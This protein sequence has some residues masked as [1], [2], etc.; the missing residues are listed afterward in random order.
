LAR[1]KLWPGTSLRR[2]QTAKDG[3]DEGGLVP[4]ASVLADSD[5]DEVV[6]GDDVHPLLRVAVEVED[7]WGLERLALLACLERVVGKPDAQ[8]VGGLA[9]GGLEHLVEVTAGDDAAAVPLA[10]VEQHQADLRPVLGFGKIE[11][12]FVGS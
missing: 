1:G 9:R 4:A 5:D 2:G 11:A 8:P 7:T 6:R 12:E 3:V 10:V